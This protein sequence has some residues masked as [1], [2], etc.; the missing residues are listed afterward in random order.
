M[1]MFPNMQIKDFDNVQV[2]PPF[3]M[4][5]FISLYSLQASGPTAKPSAV[6][7]LDMGTEFTTAPA[8]PADS[9][10]CHADLHDMDPHRALCM[11]SPLDETFRDVYQILRSVALGRRE[12]ER[13]SQFVSMVLDEST[14]TLVLSCTQIEEVAQRIRPHTTPQ[15]GTKEVYFLRAASDS[16][17][18]G[19]VSELDKVLSLTDECATP[20]FVAQVLLNI[21]DTDSTDAI[22]C[23]SRYDP[24]DEDY[25]TYYA[26]M[27]MCGVFPST[28]HSQ[29]SRAICAGAAKGITTHI[30]ENVAE[31]LNGGIDLSDGET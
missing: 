5:S 31:M 26:F 23:V 6:L 24:T 2:S 10:A 19:T 30:H 8:S 25:D 22:A 17:F 28:F 20:A 12:I 29:G 7:P 9:V 4:T 13:E 27:Y 18:G 1:Y 3:I 11:E 14:D 21:Y 16:F 15:S